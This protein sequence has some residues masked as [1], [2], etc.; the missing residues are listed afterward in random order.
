[1]LLFS[2][3]SYDPIYKLSEHLESCV[4]LR[5]PTLAS[6]QVKSCDSFSNFQLKFIHGQLTPICSCASLSL[7]T[8]D[9]KTEA[10]AWHHGS[11]GSITRVIKTSVSHP[12][13]WL[14][15]ALCRR[16]LL[17]QG[18]AP[19]QDK[20]LKRQY[21]MF[22]NSKLNIEKE[23]TRFYLFNWFTWESEVWW[24]GAGTRSWR[25]LSPQWW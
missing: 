5:V 11:A 24:S 1:M 9:A 2:D 15:T 3:T 22:K 20:Q 14:I 17:F 6:R 10:G 19:W 8:Q 13:G 12:G 25:G 21:K 4:L 18:A 16:T 7:N 23:K